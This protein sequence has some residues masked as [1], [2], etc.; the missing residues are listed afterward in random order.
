MFTGG[1]LS[2]LDVSVSGPVV[3]VARIDQKLS[4]Q[5]AIRPSV[6]PANAH[7]RDVL[8]STSII[9]LVGQTI[10]RQYPFRLMT[11]AQF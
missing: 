5:A 4:S 6:L 1:R 11:I 7:R 2:L 9:L 8:Q 3:H 10:P